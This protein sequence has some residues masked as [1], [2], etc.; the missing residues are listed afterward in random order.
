VR[1]EL[2][3]AVWVEEGP[4]L[5]LDE[6]SRLSGLPPEIIEA[7]VECS[8]LAP[9]A[10]TRSTS[11]RQLRFTGECVTTVRKAQRLQGDFDLDANALALVMRLF[12]RIHDLEFELRKLRASTPHHK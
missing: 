8:V 3:E 9:S 12:D 1:V 7:L 4:E 11:M 5:G 6:L 10:S 2:T